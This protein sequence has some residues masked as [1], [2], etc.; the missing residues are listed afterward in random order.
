[1]K[2]YIK[3]ITIFNDKKI[4][5]RIL[6]EYN[7]KINDILHSEYG[8]YS[9]AE[10]I[11]DMLYELEHKIRMQVITPSLSI[12]RTAC[13]DMYDLAKL[14]NIPVIIYGEEYCSP[15]MASF[16][17]DEY[18]VDIL[19]ALADPLNTDYQYKDYTQRMTLHRHSDFSY[20]TEDERNS[21]RRHAGGSRKMEKDL[22][23]GK[24]IIWEEQPLMAFDVEYDNIYDAILGTGYSKE[25]LITFA[26]QKSFNVIFKN[27]EFTRNI[28]NR[29]DYDKEFLSDE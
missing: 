23:T 14:N 26:R 22:N 12:N 8:S 19:K 25:A 10:M 28:I 9:K 15:S 24:P 3:S 16:E 4:K 17:R 13:E 2:D 6:L 1:M 7:I 29:Y 21:K 18:I 20:V 5:D 11:R 27:P